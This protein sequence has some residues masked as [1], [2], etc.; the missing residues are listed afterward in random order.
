MVETSI[1]AADYAFVANLLQ[2]RCALVLESGKEYL[3]K[4][5][6]APLA[7]STVWLTSAS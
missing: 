2:E 4:A 7:N 5:R 6:L 1:S 3:I